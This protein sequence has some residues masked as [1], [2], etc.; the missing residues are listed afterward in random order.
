M[1]T[2]CLALPGSLLNLPIGLYARYSA[3]KHAEEALKKSEVKLTGKDVIASKKVILGCM[4]IYDVQVVV[5][6]KLTLPMYILYTAIVAYYWGSYN[7][8]LFFTFLPFL[9][10]ATCVTI[11]IFLT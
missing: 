7:A 2:L 11:V 1:I 9:S 3:S 8:L 10:L 5:A 4:F 6:F